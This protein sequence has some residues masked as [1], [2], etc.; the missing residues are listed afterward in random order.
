MILVELTLVDFFVVG[1]AIGIAATFVVSL[2]YS[3]KQMQKL[4]INI[5]SKILNDLDDKMHH[6]SEL[7]IARPELAEI[8]DRNA[9]SQ[10]PK[11]A[12]AMYALNVFSYAFHMHQRGILRKNEW[13]GWLRLI[14]TVFKEGTISDYWRAS[15][16]EAWFDPEFQDFINNEILREDKPKAEKAVKESKAE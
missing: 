5:E 12:C 15:E 16:L 14:T 1:E 8:F 11:E 2:Y 9:G 7:A 13:N 6:L 3:R 10:S 4:S